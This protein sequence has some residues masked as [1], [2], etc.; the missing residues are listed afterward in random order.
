MLKHTLS[1]LAIVALLS[2]SGI[3]LAQDK[4]PSPG[5][6]GKPQ[7]APMSQTQNPAM[8]PIDKAPVGAGMSTTGSN[9]S[10]GLGAVDVMQVESGT[11]L[12]KV[13]GSTVYSGSGDK[14]GSIEDIVL[15]PSD[16]K[17]Y[18]IISVGGFLGIG[19]RLVAVPYDALSHG[20][21]GKIV[22]AGASK[23]ELK[24][25]PEFKYRDRTRKPS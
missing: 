5:A 8:K 18:G 23:E 14:V 10:A 1:S 17:L 15:V 9:G 20:T 19:D 3:V 13:V 11:A 12:S 6:M 7:T 16:R 25:A 22:L 4:S 24:T 2:T 21:D